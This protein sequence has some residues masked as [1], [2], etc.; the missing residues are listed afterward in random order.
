PSTT[1]PLARALLPFAREEAIALSVFEIV[2]Q[3]DEVVLSLLQSIPT[4]KVFRVRCVAQRLQA[5]LHRL[6]VRQGRRGETFP[7]FVR[8]DGVELDAMFALHPTHHHLAEGFLF[9][10]EEVERPHREA[11]AGGGEGVPHG[12]RKASRNRV[13]RVGAIAGQS[14]CPSEIPNNE[15]KDFFGIGPVWITFPQRAKASKLENVVD[16]TLQVLACR[17]ER[18]DIERGQPGALSQAL[19]LPLL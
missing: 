12:F 5:L 8:R 4:G 10:V 2:Q 16:A 7:E 18:I 14:R 9:G 19:L 13:L 17:H 11:W 6:T 1:L 15:V 3:V